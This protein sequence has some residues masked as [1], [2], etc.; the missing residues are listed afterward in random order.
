MATA[1]TEKV[2]STLVKPDHIVVL[3]KTPAGNQPFLLEPSHPT[4]D[5]LRVAIEK[6]RVARIP[7][8]VTLARNIANKTHGRVQVTKSGVTFRG[9]AVPAVISRM[10]RKVM[11]ETGRADAWLRFTENFYKNPEA[12]SR[13]ELVEFL[14]KAEA[15]NYPVPMTDNGCFMA[16]KAVNANYTD[17]HTGTVDN[18]VGATPQMPRKAVDPDRRNECSRGYH[19]C[20]LNYLQSF[21]GQRIM[22]VEV[23]PKDVVAIPADYNYSKGRTWKYHVVAEISEKNSE[24]SKK[25]APIMQQAVVPVYQER[26]ELLE[27]VLALPAL[28]RAIRRGKIAKATIEK[29]SRQQLEKLYKRFAAISAPERSK[30]L[31]NCLMDAR[32]AAALTLG[33]VAKELDIT[34]KAAWQLEHS[35][36]PR[37]DAVD[38]YLEAIAKLSGLGKG[39]RALVNFP[40]VTKSRAAAAAVSY[41]SNYSLSQGVPEVDEEDDEEDDEDFD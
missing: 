13:Q 35:A 29:Q 39:D 34:Y 26:K 30:V 3:L 32:N 37:Q 19:F 21:G 16:Y 11:K 20:S 7:A 14:E 6:G 2:V 22:A 33:Q 25:I 1:Y 17:V 27:K 38:R 31:E 36:N 9:K 12:R 24:T 5:K 8:L 23:N 15:G 4:F 41:G 40:T 18:S 28:K 10:V